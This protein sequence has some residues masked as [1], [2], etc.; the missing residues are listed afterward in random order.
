MEL[1]WQFHPKWIA[2]LETK[3]VRDFNSVDVVVTG[4]E[5]ETYLLKLMTNDRGIYE[6][7]TDIVL[8]EGSDE[9]ITIHLTDQPCLIGFF[10]CPDEK[11][12]DYALLKKRWD[13][14]GGL[15]QI[16][17]RVLKGERPDE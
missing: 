5:T 2:N 15:G 8:Q 6:F 3:D 9:P 11:H 12:R 16:L 17:E 14:R 13:D 4:Q 1:P 7:K 10:E